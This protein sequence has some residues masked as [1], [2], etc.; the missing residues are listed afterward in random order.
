MTA[1]ILLLAVTRHLTQD[2]APVPFLW[3]LPLSIYPVSYTHLDVY[4]RQLQALVV[5]MLAGTV[6]EH[7]NGFA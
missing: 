1:S 3:V 4:K 6:F 2:V 7:P 5:Q